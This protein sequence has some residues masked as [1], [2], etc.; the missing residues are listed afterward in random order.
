MKFLAKDSN[1]NQV[2]MLTE[3]EQLERPLIVE[4]IRLRQ[5]PRKSA[6]NEQ[7]VNEMTSLEQD[8]ENFIKKDIG[9][10]FADLCIKLNGSGSLVYV[11]KSILAAR[12]A[13]FEAFFRSFMPKNRKILVSD[14]T[15]L[16]W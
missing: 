9:Y 1:F 4:I 2:I 11:H 7:T 6:M 5:T 8:L 16:G 3:F 15:S 12:C 13:Y 14:L 10:E